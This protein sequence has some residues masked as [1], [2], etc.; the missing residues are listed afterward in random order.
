M[1]GNCNYCHATL[2][3]DKF[4]PGSCSSCGALADSSS[5]DY[6]AFLED[7]VSVLSLMLNGNLALVNKEGYIV[8]NQFYKRV[9]EFLWKAGV[10]NEQVT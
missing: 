1:N 9:Q 4:H 5:S 3:E 10:I 6:V 2:E 8:P 7:R